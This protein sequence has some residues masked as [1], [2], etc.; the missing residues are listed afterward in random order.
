MKGLLKY[1][2]KGMRRPRQ[3]PIRWFELCNS[4]LTIYTDGS[5][6]HVIKSYQ[7]N[8]YS[9]VE[10]LSDEKHNKFLIMIMIDHETSL[11]LAAPN[12]YVK[13]LWVD[14]L[15]TSI[16]QLDEL[17]ANTETDSSYDDVI[18]RDLRTESNGEKVITETMDKSS[19]NARCNT[20]ELLKKLP[21]TLQ[22]S[23]KDIIYATTK[24]F[25]NISF[26]WKKVLI[27]VLVLESALILTRTASGLLL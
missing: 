12:D 16:N 15:Q 9:T 25:E 27:T 11:K 24:S 22:Q 1:K 19:S 18:V 10:D 5:K 3:W 4:V 6:R 26:H 13:Y 23:G 20:T 8:N 7:L 17:E 21:S 14:A 2:K